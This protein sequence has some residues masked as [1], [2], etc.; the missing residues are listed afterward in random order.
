[1]AIIVEFI[2]AG[3]GVAEI[4]TTGG[5]T[6]EDTNAAK[7]KT[8]ATATIPN[9]NSVLVCFTFK[10]YDYN[11]RLRTIRLLQED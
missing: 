10:T 2:S 4:V 3:L 7:A 1:M 9:P 6:K 8:I 5:K 11:Q